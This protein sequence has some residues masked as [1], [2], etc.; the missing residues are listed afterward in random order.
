MVD[1]EALTKRRGCPYVLAGDIGGTHMRAAL[2][3]RSGGLVAR[4][5]CPTEP[6]RGID[7]AAG[8]LADLLRRAAADVDRAAIGGAVISTAG[9]VDPQTGIYDHPPNLRGWDGHTMKPQL[10][11]SLRMPVAIGHDATLAALAET[12]YGAGV[13]ARHLVYVTVSTGIG[14]G[15]IANGEMVTGARGHAGEL[16]HILVKPGGR[17]CNVGCNGCLE[18]MASGAGIAHAARTV[19]ESGAQTSLS[20]MCGGAPANVD[21][22][23][24]FRA[25]AEGDAAAGE[26][27][28]EAIDALALGFAS[29][30]NALDPEV[31]VVG[32]AVVRGLSRRWEEL[33]KRAGAY[34]LPHFR[35]QAPLVISPL[36][37][38]VSLIG[39]AALA[40]DYADGIAAG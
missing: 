28:E 26:I 25:A 31:L 24:V 32:G 12:R 7:D 20:E 2:A 17:G 40:F 22:A 38:D 10:A 39:A 35:G 14:G 9:P 30:L 16:G 11:E 1:P 5:S 18:G 36:G 23:M 6:E 3:D 33:V 27:V 34:A 29:I 19:L 37:D 8:R 4:T 21:S 13:G 15:I